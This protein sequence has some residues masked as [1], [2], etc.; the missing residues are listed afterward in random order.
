MNGHKTDANGK[1][2]ETIH[3]VF[4]KTQISLVVGTVTVLFLVITFVM[5]YV[6]KQNVGR[7]QPNQQVVT[8]L[9]NQTAILNTIKGKVD[10]NNIILNA[11]TTTL[12]DTKQA[13]LDNTKVLVGIAKVLEQQTR[14]LEAQTGILQRMAAQVDMQFRKGG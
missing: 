3:I 11:R 8:I 14:L 9:E 10:D 2:T 13:S 7:N 4:T 6:D 12:A 5:N 1:I